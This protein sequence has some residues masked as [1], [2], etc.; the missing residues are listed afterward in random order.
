MKTFREFVLE[1]SNNFDSL[2]DIKLLNFIEKDDGLKTYFITL[3]GDRKMFISELKSIAN[4]NKLSP[5]DY[6][7]IYLIFHKENG[8]FKDEEE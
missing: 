6:N 1:V 5:S 7:K 4:D 8:I 2:D 3:L